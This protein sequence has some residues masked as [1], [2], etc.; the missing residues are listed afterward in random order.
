[1]DRTNE[2][3]QRFGFTEPESELY[4]AILSLGK[5]S[6]TQIAKKIGKNRAAVY[7]HLKHLLE[8]GALKETREGR[9]FRF[10]AVPPA[11][12]AATF[13][14][15]T[16]EFKSIVPQLESLSR[17]EQEVPVIEIFESK[18]GYLK[19][20]D[21]L[22]SLPVGSSFRAMEGVTALKG[23]LGL[24]TDE[25]WG[26]FFSRLVE[27]KIQTKIIFTEEALAASPPQQ[28]LNAE[29]MKRVRQRLWDLR[30]LPESAFPMQSLMILYGNKAAFLLPDAKLI[31]TISHKGV[32]EALGATF[33]ALFTFAQKREPAWG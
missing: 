12:L 8:K 4:L 31:V 25:E 10:V 2:V 20:Y 17:A 19:V 33:D 15:W 18:K 29:N 14:R 28:S 6:V 11:D 1:M 5:P 26:T 23:E 21:E 3:L 13:D 24:L 16:T 22:S 32:S 9:R 30:I 27:R 7:F